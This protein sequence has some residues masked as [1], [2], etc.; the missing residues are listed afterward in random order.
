MPA[1]DLFGFD[2]SPLALRPDRLG[3]RVFTGN[4]RRTNKFD[5][6]SSHGLALSC[7][8]RRAPGGRGP[9]DILPDAIRC[10][11]S[12]HEVPCPFSVSPHTAA[13]I[14]T[15]FA[16][17]D[18]LRPQVFTTSRRFHPPCA[19]R[20]CFM[21]VPLMGLRPSELF[22]SREAVRRLRRL[23]PPGVGLASSSSGPCSS[24]ESATGKLVV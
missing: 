16:S 21:P 19:C 17:P 8:V 9:S 18:R 22:Y 20:P 2:R 12:F 15:G 14:L 5:R 10:H 23:C 3:S 4:G 1:S 6:R 13:A 7:R 11:G 24:R